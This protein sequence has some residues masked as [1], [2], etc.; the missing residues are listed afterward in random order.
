MEMEN[1]Q[2]LSP[3]PEIPNTPQQIKQSLWPKVLVISLVVAMGIVY[4]LGTRNSYERK[5]PSSTSSSTVPSVQDFSND[6][7]SASSDN[8]QVI[9]PKGWKTYSSE[10]V[11]SLPFSAF[12][13]SHPADWKETFQYLDTN[14][15]L[16]FVFIL[17]EQ[18][19]D[20]HQIRIYQGKGVA[21]SCTFPG[22]RVD[23]PSSLG[24]LV[25]REP[26]SGDT[27]ISLCE[28]SKTE[29]R[30]YSNT[31]EVGV[32][33]YQLH[34]YREPLKRDFDPKLLEEMD[35]IIGTLTK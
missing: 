31:T 15:E 21:S 30:T 4:V 13:I 8:T 23:V 7:K 24:Q 12:S 29:P 9:I 2:P 27:I 22:E 6:S 19:K 11:D 5:E 34:I 14:H 17:D 28:K 10:K 16:G 26:K 35:S 33:S 20:D 3:T 25:R 1:I 32:I 18:D